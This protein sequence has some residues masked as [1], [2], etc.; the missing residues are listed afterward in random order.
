METKRE[1]EDCGFTIKTVLFA[2]YWSDKEVHGIVLQRER[3][4]GKNAGN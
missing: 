4:D 2:A 3:I 1:I